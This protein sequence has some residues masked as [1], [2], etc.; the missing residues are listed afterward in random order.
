M[1]A[2]YPTWIPPTL[3]P[4]VAANGNIYIVD[5]ETIIRKS[6]VLLLSDAGYQCRPYACGSDLIDALDY[7]DPGCVLLDVNM[8]DLDGLAVQ[9]RLLDRRPDLPIIFM[10]AAGSI[11]MAV[12]V[13]KKGAVDFIEK[14]FSD[15][16]L[17]EL[18]EAAQDKLAEMLRASSRSNEAAARLSQLTPR[19]TEVMRSL[20]RGDGNKTVAHTLQLST[21]TVEMHRAS[22]MRKIGVHNFTAAVQVALDAG[23]KPA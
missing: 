14:P 10:T 13:I 19:E 11:S 15:E 7:L 8:P 3:R 21:R 20:L 4:H 17:L 18:V 6:L 16:L 1:L 22:I 23:L 12:K 2:T 5:D 9:E